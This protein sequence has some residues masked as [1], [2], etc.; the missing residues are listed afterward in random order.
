VKLHKHESNGFANPLIGMQ[1]DLPCEIPVVAHRQPLEQ[2]AA[3]CIR[4][5]TGLHPPAEA[6]SI[7]Q[8]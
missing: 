6:L 1:D 3:T 8:R 7:R 5:L 4:F 2:L